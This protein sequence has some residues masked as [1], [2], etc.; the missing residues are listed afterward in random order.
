MRTI[1][2]KLVIELEAG[3]RVF[4]AL[5]I[6][7]TC[8]S[9]GTPL[10]ALMITEQGEQSGTIGGG[11]M[12]QRLFQIAQNALLKDS[13]QTRLNRLVHQNT[14]K[15]DASGLICGGSQTNLLAV[16]DYSHITIAKRVAENITNDRP[17]ILSIS[18][19]A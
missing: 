6:E 12:E 9:P 5:V 13:Y 16:L 19:E 17:G 14:G 10:S 8:G 4:L 7:S 18:T 15:E 11:R 3:K 2:N 1:W